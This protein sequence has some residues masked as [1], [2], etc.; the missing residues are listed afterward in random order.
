[1]P[2]NRRSPGARGRVGVLLPG[3]PRQLRRAGIRPERPRGEG[4][5]H[6]R[7]PG[8][9][10]QS[11]QRDG[12]GPGRA[13]GIGLRRVQPRGRRAGRDLRMDADRRRHH[14]A[15]PHRRCRGPAP[16]G[17]RRPARRTGARQRAVARRRRRRFGPRVVRCSP[18]CCRSASP[19]TRWRR[20]GGG[21]ICCASSAATCTPPRGRR[22]DST[23]PRSGC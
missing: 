16:A 6:A 9:L 21:A 18:A 17:A 2:S 19:T 3:V 20:C 12:S 13:G 5:G 4:R 10:H 11:R 15:G 8:L 23:P 1:M 7:W 14:R 22:P